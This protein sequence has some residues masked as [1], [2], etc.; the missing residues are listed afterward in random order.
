M[1]KAETAGKAAED[2]QRM[3]QAASDIFLGWTKGAEEGR[4]ARAR[5][6]GRHQGDPVGTAGGDRRSLSGFR[7]GGT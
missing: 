4:P 6:R 2:P 7:W 5:L 3:M 1:K